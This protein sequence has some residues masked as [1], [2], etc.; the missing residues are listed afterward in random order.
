MKISAGLTAGLL[1]LWVAALLAG[2]S[3]GSSSPSA[4]PSP[5][6]TPIVVTQLPASV[7]AVVGQSIT[8]TLTSNASTGYSWSAY[9]TGND[10]IVSVDGP[11]Y[12]PPP[13]ASAMPGAPG[14]AT[15]V[16][17]GLKPGTQVVSF[18]YSRPSDPASAEVK[19]LTVTINAPS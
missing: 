7:N 9:W 10:G 8:V 18:T 1:P 15:T 3:S 6:V 4:S 12:S 5:T 19:N 13:S 17:R 14:T 16:I 11:S 2:C